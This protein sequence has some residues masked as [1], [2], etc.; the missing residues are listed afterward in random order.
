MH[1]RG[2]T[3]R[4]LREHDLAGSLAVTGPQCPRGAEPWTQV[5]ALV[6]LGAVE[7]RD[8]L[9]AEAGGEG[10]DV[11][12]G[13]LG[14]SRVDP[15]T[16]LG[17]KRPALLA[18]TPAEDFEVALRGASG[19][20]QEE[21]EVPDGLHRIV[22]LLGV[23]ENQ[24]AAEL[25]VLDDDRP[26]AFGP[27]GGGRHSAEECA[28][29][30]HAA[31][32][33]VVVQP[34]RIRD[35]DLAGEQRL[36]ARG[37]VPGAQ[38]GVAAGGPAPARAGHPVAAVLEGLAGQGDAPPGLAGEQAFERHRCSGLVEAG[39]SLDEAAACRSI[40][41]LPAGRSLEARH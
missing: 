22:L 30:Q 32:H 6:R 15:H 13:A 21:L 39:D 31:E 7:G 25:Q 27:D 11:D 36:A 23:W 5:H 4:R 12:P 38:Q 10:L 20:L 8:V 24:R 41:R 1:L 28:R 3:V 19:V 18:R 35:G 9:R 40:S 14:R 26:A 16:A 33:P 34:R 37:L 2:A 17:M 29:H